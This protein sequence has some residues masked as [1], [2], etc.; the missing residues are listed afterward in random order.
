MIEHD[1]DISI[2]PRQEVEEKDYF[3]NDYWDWGYFQLNNVPV[4]DVSSIVVTFLR[5]E[6]G[7]PENIL[8]I[9]TNWIRLREHDGIIRLVPNNKF[10]AQLQVD[11]AGTFFP[12]IFR[13]HSNVPQ[14]WTITY[15]AG[16]K[17]GKIPIILNTAIGL[18]AAILAFNNAAD[19]LLGAGI[20]AT[21]LSIDGLQQSI[22]STASAE[23]HT[24]SAK[25]KE[26]GKLLWG[27]SINSPNRG[28]IRSLRDFYQG[29]RLN[30][31]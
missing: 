22:T 2:M 26:Y 4:S 18:L 15:T 11:A 6:D 20:A 17:D 3:G 7:T 25:V 31:I 12:E 10:P 24:Y 21:S 13:R 29:N 30:I 8:D 14:L 27:E 5:N 28:I 1:L 19:L 9:P 23:N 16:F